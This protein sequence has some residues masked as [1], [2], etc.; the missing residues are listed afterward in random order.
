MISNFFNIIFYKP[1]YNGLISIFNIIPWV[2]AGIVVII[3]TIVVKLILFPLSVKATK[4]QLQ[5]K[6]IEKDL[7][8][9]KEKYKDNKEEQAKQI[10]N[11]YKDRDI[12]PFSGILILIIQLPIIIALYRVFLVSGL[13]NVTTELLYW[14]VHVPDFI[15]MNF[16]GIL[17]IRNKST[18]LAL[19]SGLTSFL[20]FKYAQPLE[21]D[22]NKNSPTSDFSRIMQIQM[23]FG[24]PILMF[25]I[26]RSLSSA[27]ALYFITS[28][29][30][31]I[32][33]ELY[34]RKHIRKS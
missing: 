29:V 18:I 30:F 13:P 17:D 20:Q 34:I 31:T 9:I 2:D 14:F 21:S 19:L 8:D 15:N 7:N 25:I 28:N 1:L 6:S 5:M 10:V 12:N 23:K 24:F 3:F 32:F 4:S 27:I 26:S 11:L 33:Q 22:T 16:L